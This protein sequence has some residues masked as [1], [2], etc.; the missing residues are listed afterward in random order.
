MRQHRTVV[1]RA[2]FLPQ[3]SGRTPAF[4]HVKPSNQCDDQ[5]H[6]GGKHNYFRVQQIWIH[7]KTSVMLGTT[8]QNVACEALSARRTVVAQAGEG[9]GTRTNVCPY[10]EESFW[11]VAFTPDRIP[12]PR[13][14]IAP[15]TIHCVGICI[16]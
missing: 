16:R 3:V 12:T 6:R 10:S 11:R 5:N 2:E 1:L 15:V 4:S 7:R 8:E 14:T 9:C 13:S